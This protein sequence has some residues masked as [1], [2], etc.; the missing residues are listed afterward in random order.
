LFC[1]VFCFLVFWDRVSLYSSGYP[2]TH[3]VDQAG[4]Q[5]RNSPA[6][7]SQVL[8]LKACATTPGL[9]ACFETGLLCNPGCPRNSLCRPA[10]LWT[11]RS[12]CL[13]LLS[14]I[15]G[16]SYH[17]RLTRRGFKSASGSKRTLSAC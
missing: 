13:C 6:S 12:T 11:Q 17:T 9:L 3:F 1:F 8:G 14:G 15:K 2:G 4:L 16:V 7:A 5:L 10:W